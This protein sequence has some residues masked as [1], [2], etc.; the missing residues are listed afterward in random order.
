MRRRLGKD[1]IYS[2]I[3][4][5]KFHSLT[6]ESGEREILDCVFHLAYLCQG[7]PIYDRARVYAELVELTEHMDFRWDLPD[8][9]EEMFFDTLFREVARDRPKQ[10]LSNAALREP[11]EDL[12]W[13]SE[14]PQEVEISIS[15]RRGKDG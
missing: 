2:L 1:I 14:V 4:V 11:V 9:T 8:C 13:E 3:Q 6:T 15:R 7:L 10:Q 5:C 12:D